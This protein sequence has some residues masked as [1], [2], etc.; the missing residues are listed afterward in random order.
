MKRG[1]STEIFN[2]YL[3]E[4]GIDIPY[5]IFVEAYVPIAREQERKAVNEGHKEPNYRQ[6]I[7]D[8][9]RKL[10]IKEAEK[11]S[12][13]AWKY[14]LKM[15]PEQTEYFQ[16][17]PEM[18]NELKKEYKLGIITNYMDG[19]TCREVFTNLG[20][21]DIFDTLIISHEMGYMKPAEI[22][23]KTAMNDTKSTPRECIMVG[24][25]YKADIVGGNL[26][27]MTTVLVDVYNNQ[28]EYYHECSAV[29]RN[30]NEF[31]D[32]LHKLKSS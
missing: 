14:Y 1:S 24:D 3:A 5:D 32:S 27:G 11:Y 22:L 7:E 31:P 20:Y 25:T 30:I 28:Q 23:F 4:K 21:Y 15:W 26:A 8:V 18:L 12:I 19:P 10:N 9:F 6:R 2:K 17:V 16:G 29:I 13:G